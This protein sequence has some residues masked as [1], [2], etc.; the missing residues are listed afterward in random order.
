[1]IMV[2]FLFFSFSVPPTA[3]FLSSLF[4]SCVLIYHNCVP[5][6]FLDFVLGRHSASSLALPPSLLPSP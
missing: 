6:S 5:F 1:M 3:P 4:I 2:G